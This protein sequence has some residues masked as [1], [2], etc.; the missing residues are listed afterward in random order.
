VK[1]FALYK[2][3]L[4][5]TE[6]EKKEML[7]KAALAKT[8]YM[9]DLKTGECTEIDAAVVGNM[10]RQFGSD[11]YYLDE[12]YTGEEIRQTDLTDNST[13]VFAEN[14]GTFDIIGNYLYFTQR[15][16]ESSDDTDAK[17]K[18]NII[19]HNLKTGETKVVGSYPGGHVCFT[20]YGYGYAENDESD[21]VCIKYY[22][23]TEK[24]YT[25][26]NISSSN[27]AFIVNQQHT[28]TIEKAEGM[29]YNNWIE[30]KVVDNKKVSDT[31]TVKVGSENCG[32]LAYLDGIAYC[33]D[34]DYYEEK[35]V[36]P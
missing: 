32:V 19:K 5:F 17:N 14:V 23:G 20:S 28:E 18:F 25:G 31:I 30:S 29:M 12:A 22:D 6:F 8:N 34:G 2:D 35:V 26:S 10:S 33:Y 27:D 11:V 4:Y 7:G 16:S 24:E 13:S 15:K 21:R 36:F 9:Y 1:I 3:K